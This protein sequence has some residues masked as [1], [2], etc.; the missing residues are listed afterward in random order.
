MTEHR[1]VKWL[2]NIINNPDD[3]VMLRAA[4]SGTM[5]VD[6]KHETLIT[7]WIEEMDH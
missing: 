6:T 2:F 4:V 5:N 7:P 1:K 3:N